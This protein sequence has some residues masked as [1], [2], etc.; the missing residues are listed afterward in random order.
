MFKCPS[1]FFDSRSKMA[2]V[3]GNVDA[4]TGGMEEP[5]MQIFVNT[6]SGTMFT[7]NVK[8]SDGLQ[9]VKEKIR[10]EQGIPKH[11]CELVFGGAKLFGT[12]NIE[13]YNI[14]QGDTLRLEFHHSITRL[15]IAGTAHGGP[16]SGR[17][18]IIHV[19]HPRRYTIRDI[20]A[21]IF[22]ATGI[23]AGQQR[24]MQGDAT[25]L[26]DDMSLQELTIQ[27]GGYWQLQCEFV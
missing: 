16:L 19:D 2:Y 23:P 9:D 15:L 3:G 24:L 4:Y 17:S 20:K 22:V 18:L 13:T 14:R 7:L 26:E 11:L 12:A 1:C 8:K 6:P 27:D 25:R 5:S 10:N 21:K